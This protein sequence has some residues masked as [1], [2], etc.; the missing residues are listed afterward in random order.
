[1][2]TRGGSLLPPFLRRAR[3][4]AL[5]LLLVGAASCEKELD[6]HPTNPRSARLRDQANLPPGGLLSFTEIRN[7]IFKPS[8]AL[9]D[10]CHKQTAMGG[11]DLLTDP[12]TALVDATP[13]NPTASVRNYKRVTVYND[14]KS[15]LILKMTLPV[16]VDPSQP[17]S[18]SPTSP[19]ASK[20]KNS[21]SPRFRG[22]SF[23]ARS[24]PP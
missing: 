3:S 16:A 9:S 14:D 24:S 15:F 1:M 10:S 13:N 21:A 17:P 8:C 22:P 19:P 23:A 5:P 11:L 2:I 18:A 4:L 12:W 20:S 7:K 6:C